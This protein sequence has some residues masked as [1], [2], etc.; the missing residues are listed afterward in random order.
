MAMSGAGAGVNGEEAQDGGIEA[1][2]LG[3]EMDQVFGREFAGAV[4]ETGAGMAFSVAGSLGVS[5]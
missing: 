1:I 3:I 2:A 4:R 5:P